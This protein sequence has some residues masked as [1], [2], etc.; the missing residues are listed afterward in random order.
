MH[1]PRFYQL[2]GR[3]ALPTPTLIDPYRAAS[4]A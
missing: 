4:G 1:G 3:F 2:L